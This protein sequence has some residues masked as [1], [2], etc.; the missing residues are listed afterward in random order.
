[1]TDETV[2]APNDA[3]A[4]DND[5]DVDDFTDPADSDA[6]SPV[7]PIDMADFAAPADVVDAAPVKAAEPPPPPD[8][9]S[10]IV[11]VNPD[12]LS[13]TPPKPIDPL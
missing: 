10:A 1:M 9:A 2:P 5:S 11:S 7:M 8:C 4:P 6:D 12:R 3:R 13:E